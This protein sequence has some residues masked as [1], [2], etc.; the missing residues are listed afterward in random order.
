MSGFIARLFGADRRAALRASIRANNAIADFMQERSFDA[1]RFSRELAEWHW[2]GG[3]ENTD[4]LGSLPTIRARSREMAKNSP[5]YARFIQLM[6][7]NVVGEGFRFKALPHLRGEDPTTLDKDAARNLEYHWWRWC[8]NPYLVDAG[9][10]LTLTQM[11]MLAVENWARDGEAFLLLDLSAQNRYG[12]SLRIIR[13]D[14]IDETVNFTTSTG[15]VVR[16]GI[17]FDADTGAP[18]A[19]YFNGE[20]SDVTSTV[21]YRGKPR[22]RID[23]RYVIH[24]YE[25][26]DAGQVR[27]VP[28]GYAALVP[29]KMLE[30][31]TREE[32]TAARHEACTVGVFESP[33][34]QGDPVA[35]VSDKSKNQARQ[36]I[37][38][39]QELWLP[40]GYKYSSHT[41]SHPNRGWVDYSVGLQRL[42]ST[43]LGVDFSEL[44]GNGAD[45]ISVVARQAMLRTREM[46]KTRQG[47]V[48]SLVLDRLWYAW[49][50]SFLRLSISGDLTQDDFDRLGDHDF[51]GR[52][53]GWVEPTAEVNAAA[54]AVAHGWRTDAEVAAEFGNDI[55]D[56]ITEAERI[57]AAKEQA[58]LITVGNGLGS[59]PAASTSE[60]GKE[61]KQEAK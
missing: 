48:I 37:R 32:L 43:G 19:Y 1:A 59:Q 36:M 34:A 51:Q 11:L 61:E 40:S 14:C 41:P 45:T 27:G 7:E 15:R 10:R 23:A 52:R 42:I 16:G 44:T 35:N 22:M 3:W 54:I 6:R 21:Y 56:D 55:D 5:L 9:R 17:E 26:H 49:L 39:G 12:I 25:R 29:L 30:Q 2:D 13:A 18:T 24:L 33:Y 50:R 58:G 31:Y 47:A 57:K 8:R 60:S 28:L 46:Y 38:S 20:C 53:W 4:V